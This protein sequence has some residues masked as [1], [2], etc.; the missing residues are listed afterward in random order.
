MRTRLA[1]LLLLLATA[2]SPAQR[3]AA[4]IGVGVA[5]AAVTYRAV[6]WVVPSCRQRS[7]PHR[8][9][10]D[11]SEPLPSKAA[12]PLALVGLGVVVVGGLLVA[13]AT[14][15]R[16]VRQTSASAPPVLPEKPTL[17]DSTE[18]VGMV[19]A[20]LVVG[21][22]DAHARPA[23]R[24]E[25]DDTEARLE[26]LGARAQLSNLRIRTS[27]EPWRVVRACYEFEKEWRLT[28]LGPTADC[29]P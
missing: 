1:S 27:T 16:G 25:V 8:G 11:H 23:K 13:S 26:T 22:T 24:H 4:G 6:S 2:C 12:F 19:V 3:T 28:S 9:C 5:G 17:L 10:L 20:R 29:L 14:G 21:S 7:D 15:T 18:A